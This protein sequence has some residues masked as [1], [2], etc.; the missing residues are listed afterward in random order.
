MAILYI[1]RIYS[2]EAPLAREDGYHPAN[3]ISYYLPAR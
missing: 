2:S 1:K 3:E